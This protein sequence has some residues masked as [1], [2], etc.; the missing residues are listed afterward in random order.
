V[1]LVPESKSSIGIV[2]LDIF[3]LGDVWLFGV[4]IVV[5]GIVFGCVLLSFGH[6]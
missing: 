5:F 2:L 1:I 4:L 6:C 3:V